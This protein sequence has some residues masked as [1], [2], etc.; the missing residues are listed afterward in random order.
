MSANDSPLARNAPS[1]GAGQEDPQ[2]R[3]RRLEALGR[4]TA[5]IAHEINTPTQFAAAS[6]EFV[7][8]VVAGLTRALREQR[9]L[10]AQVAAGELTAAE[11]QR[12]AQDSAVDYLMEEAPRAVD[13]AR[14]GLRR[15]GRIVHSVR[16]HAHLRDGE[17]LV[18]TDVNAQVQAALELTRAEYKYDADVVTELGDLPPVPGDAGDLSQAIVNLLVNAA[19]AIREKRACGGG[20]GTITVTTR[21]L[22]D[23]VEIAVSD[24]GC[25]IPDELRDRIFEPFFTTKAVGQGTG[26]GL[27]IARA[28][29]VDRHHGILTVHSEPDRGATFLIALPCATPGGAS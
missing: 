17:G 24:T 1:E 16:A 21:A 22:P 11:A 6:L 10:L 20:R 2:R 5:G 23:R 27:S 9:G 14:Q 19:Q 25:G 7:A 26:Q 12:L 13:D 29:V 3:A 28:T 8:E 15:I 4:L 18:P